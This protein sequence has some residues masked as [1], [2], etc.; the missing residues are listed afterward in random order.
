MTPFALPGTESAQDELTRRLNTRVP[1]GGK[2][3]I[4]ET[5][6]AGRQRS[7]IA[8]RRR[9]FQQEQDLLPCN[10]RCRSRDRRSRR[11][12]V[13]RQAFWRRANRGRAG[14]GAELVGPARGP[15]LRGQLRGLSRLVRC[16][17][18][19]RP[20][21]GAPVLRALASRRQCDP[22]RRAARGTAPSLEVRP[23]AQGRRER[24]PARGY[25]RLRPRATT[26]EWN[27]MNAT[28]TNRR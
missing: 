7:S 26:G 23:H 11:L 1:I 6:V 25:R 18:G 15:R 19:D 5:T 24:P 17:H 8:D 16:W 27:S 14:A 21:S 3:K 10:W 9:S 28:R 22:T 4:Q 13:R 12:R 2:A 20:A